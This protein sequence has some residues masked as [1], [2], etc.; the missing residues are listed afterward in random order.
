[1]NKSSAKKKNDQAY[2]KDFYAWA[3]NNSRLLKQGRI[4]E[5]D[6]ENI[7]EEIES[8][9]KSERREL[10]NCFAVL[11]AHLIKWLHKPAKRS[12]SW[13]LTI[14]EQRFEIVDLLTDSPSLKSD[15][16]KQMS[17]AYEKALIIAEKETGLKKKNF[18]T[19]CPFSLKQLLDQKFFPE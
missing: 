17:H 12:K 15:L 3:I 2:N 1:M 11:I 7:A 10:L 6:V 9:G 5:I 16:E 8:I 13:E 4:S 19:K 14:K 18:D